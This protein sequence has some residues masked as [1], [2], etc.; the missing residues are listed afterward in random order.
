LYG[1]QL[2]LELLYG[3]QLLLELLYGF[4]LL[5]IERYICLVCDAGNMF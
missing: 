1:F 4:Q 5:F 3:F 2:L